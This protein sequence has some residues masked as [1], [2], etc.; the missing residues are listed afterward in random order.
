[1]FTVKCF[2]LF[3]QIIAAVKASNNDMNNPTERSP[4]RQS[5]AGGNQ[6]GHHRRISTAMS[7]LSPFGRGDNEGKNFTK[8]LQKSSSV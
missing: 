5:T 4:L 7:F 3:C 1:M 8:G 6:G 2:L